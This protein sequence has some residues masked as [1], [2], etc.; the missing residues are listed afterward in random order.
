[1][2]DTPAQVQ[3]QL[4]GLGEELLHRVPQLGGLFAQHDAAITIQDHDVLNR[5]SSNFQLHGER[6]LRISEK[7]SA[8]KP[9]P[10]GAVAQGLKGANLLAFSA[11][12][13]RFRKPP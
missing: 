13:S 11:S 5:T 6:S 8:E 1:M 7:M 2:Y 10:S 3:Y 12:R 9:T 4:L